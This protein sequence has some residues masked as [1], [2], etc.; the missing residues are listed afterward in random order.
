MA[1]APPPTVDDL[2][3][4]GCLY[5]AALLQAQ[6]GRLRLAPTQRASLAALDLLRELGVIEV[7]WPEPRWAVRP[8]AEILPIEGM[9]WAYRWP[10]YTAA[11]VSEA[12]TDYLSSVPRDDYALG[13]RVRIWEE[14]ALGEAERFYEQQLAKHRFDPAWAADLPFVFRTAPPT[15]S[16]AQWRY[17]GWAAVRHGA[18]W[19]LQQPPGDS[20]GVREAIYAELK[21]R[22]GH[23]HSGA[24]GHC[25]LPPFH[26]HPES[27]L[28]RTF[29]KQLCPAGVLY[30]TE[31]PSAP[32]LV[33]RLTPA[34]AA[35]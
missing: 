16:I 15:L 19:A 6:G 29:V 9:Q 13:L 4:R 18:S 26:P 7:P 17:C 24:W 1:A 30:W 22:V 2:G 12:L 27:A 34:S 11:S 10:A 25:A 3:L 5:L 35:R 33:M 14:L 21:R 31:L 20:A 23:V 28:A 32:A 8:D